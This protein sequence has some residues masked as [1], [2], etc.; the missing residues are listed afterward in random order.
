MSATATAARTGG[1]IGRFRIVRLLGKGN[2]S[3][4]YLAHDS[5]LDRQVAIKTLFFADAADRAAKMQSLLKEARTVSKLSHP[6]IIPLYDAG[7]YEGQPYLV[8]EYVDGRTLADVLQAEGP[9][10]PARAAEIAA[11]VLDAIACAHGQNIV[12]RDL[13]PSNIILD[14]TSTPRVTDFGIA[15]QV[16]AEG[17]REGG[18]TGTP[19]YMAP[20]YVRDQ[21]VGPRSDIFAMGLVLHEMLTGK[22]AV[23]G[24]SLQEILHKIVNEPVAA[25]SGAN[26]QVDERLDDI[27]LK[28]VAKDPDARY[29]DAGAMKNALQLYLAP[30]VGEESEGGAA[31]QSTLDFLLRR[32]RVK[33]DFPAL[34]EAISTINRIAGSDNDSVNKLSNAILKDFG[35]T[36]KLLKL[37]NSVFYVQYGGGT[38]ST[39][40]R[41]VVILGFNAVRNL[42]ISL[43]LFENLQN[44]GHAAQLKEE[45]VRV[46]FSG[47]LAREMAP[48]AGVKDAEEGFI[49]AMFHTLGRMLSLFYFPEETE[50][51]RKLM[52]TR[53]LSEANAATQVLG[54]SFEELGVGIARNWGFP[55]QITLSMRKLPEGTVRRGSTNADKLRIL[56]GF[57]NELAAAISDGRPE[58][59]GA[60]I[61]RLSERFGEGIALN[62]KHLAE[63]VTKSLHEVTQFSTAVNASF[64]QSSFARQANKWAG[65]AAAPAAAPAGP[66]ADTQAALAA[67]M[68]NEPAVAEVHPAEVTGSS[69][70]TAAESQAALMAGLQEIS[71]SLVNDNISVNDIIPMILETM[72][73]GMGFNRVLF[74]I[75]DG[76]HNAMHGKFGFGQDINDLVAGFRFPMASAPDVFHVALEKNVDILI[77]DID[78]PKIAGRVPDW[79]R[80]KVPARTFLI[81]PIV[82]KGKPL[83]MIYADKP[84]AGDI[85]IPEQLLGT[86][87]ALRNQAVLAIRQTL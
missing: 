78:D 28:A 75:K 22:P 18:L 55:D 15:A 24:R 58:E 52:Q 48:K 70:P 50:E 12:H 71:N 84:G 8:F 80:Q 77:T 35:L 1:T 42:A 57:S 41:A 63:V 3:E 69:G 74:C 82:V 34:S 67:T 83:G 26:A 59:R 81:F 66:D 9:L 47:M 20:E 32:M 19:S 37:V 23:R 54:L 51:I 53:S 33:S 39:V 2:Q 86:L 14:G 60:E 79:Y 21:Q 7:E 49:C 25:P 56:S 27:V 36:N 5:H 76:R 4:V 68:L 72:Y 64:G 62:A 87:K 61:A 65:H 40:S 13:K 6:N 38:I 73:S 43:V 29:G 45:F 46:L 31:K 17:A 44:K 85:V 11:Q 30:S 10:P 16:F